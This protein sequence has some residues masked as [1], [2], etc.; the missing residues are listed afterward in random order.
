MKKETKIYIEDLD[1]KTLNQFTSAM[2][3]DYAVKG[4]LMPD[5]HLGYSLAIGGVVATKGVIVPAWV[6]YDIGCG[7]CALKTS[8]NKNEVEPHR[9]DIFE[10]IYRAVPTGF[11][12]HKK[13]QVWDYKKIPMTPV[14]KSIFERNGL[15][16][17]GTLGGGNHF[18]EV[19]YDEDDVVWIVLHS[20]SRNVGHSVAG[21]YMK[22]ASGST[23]AKEGHYG[24]DVESDEGQNYITDM[25]FCLAFALENR[26]RIVDV[27]L[28]EI[29]HRVR[30][31]GKPETL[32]FINCHHNHAEL[33]D[34]LWIHR[35]GATHAEKG[36][37]GII[38]GNMR[39]GSFV[40]EGKGNPDSLYSSSHGA[41]RAMSRKKAKS[42]ITMEQFRKQ[43]EGITA[44]VN[45][46]TL[47]EAPT[48]YKDIF[49]IMRL[50]KDMVDIKH[51]LKPIIN[52][53][54]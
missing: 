41:G 23:K 6:G 10:G 7:V 3:Q 40:V 50:Q 47:D 51:H 19:S 8:L 54:A 16:Q 27:S 24:L 9:K 38:P 32:E 4:A 37:K 35:K 22:V 39:D 12:H 18:I 46:H 53:K 20:G 25:D 43:L 2:N 45:G 36:M 1:E 17:L 21:H 49:E 48:A 5:A 13:A 26:K 29:W 42:T 52:V 28:N 33:K 44:K 31:D 15:E 30:R 11:T 14:L 34:G